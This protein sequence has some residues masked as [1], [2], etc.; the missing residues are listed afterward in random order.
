M[1][2]K[3]KNLIWILIFVVF[4]G[5]AY[6]AY[7][8]LLAGYKTQQES[9]LQNNISSQDDTKNSSAPDFMVFD[10]KGREIKLSDF[11]SK[12]VVLNFWASWC[13]PCRGEMP[14][15]NEVYAQAG[16]DVIF[17]MVD[18]VDGQRETQAKGQ[19]FIEEQGYD[20]PVYF[21]N[22]QTAAQIY[23]ISSIPTTYIINS[24]GNIVKAYRGAID[25]DTLE[26]GIDLLR[27]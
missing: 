4:L 21:D 11:K 9:Q 25:K 27:Q 22:E 23:G 15:F 26:K 19:D 14:H 12:P 20:F 1:N 6:F 17:M 8:N 24:E 3:F 2:A 13:P 10:N 18:L 16:K 5:L 7:Q